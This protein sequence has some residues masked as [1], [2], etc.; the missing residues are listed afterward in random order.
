M[1]KKALTQIIRF[2]QKTAPNRIRNSCRFEPTCSEYMIIS[3]DKY[4]ISKG[5][6]NGIKRLQRCKPPNGGIDNP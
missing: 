1:M 4:G 5:V 6:L 3:I 2:Y